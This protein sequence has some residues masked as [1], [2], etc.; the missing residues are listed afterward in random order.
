MATN[1]NNWLSSAVDFTPAFDWG[2]SNNSGYNSSGN[3][4]AGNAQGGSSSLF[5]SVAP[6]KD[7]G[8]GMFGDMFG[9]DMFKKGSS[10]QGIMGAGK[11]MFD[12]YSAYQGNKQRERALDLMEDQFKFN[13]SSQTKSYNNSVRSKMSGNSRWSQDDI[14]AAMI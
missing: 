11:G 14:A 10:F 8:S 13:K 6:P 3:Y 7:N 1:S 2:G 12:A 4:S 5:P 9:S